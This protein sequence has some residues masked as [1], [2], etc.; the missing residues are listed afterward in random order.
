MGLHAAS[1]QP[2]HHRI[3]LLWRY[4]EHFGSKVMLAPLYYAFCL[5]ILGWWRTSSWNWR[6]RQR[7]PTC[8][9]QSWGISW[10]HP[11]AHIDTVSGW[12]LPDDVEW[13]NSATPTF[14]IEDEGIRD[15]RKT[16]KNIASS[17]ICPV[18]LRLSQFEG[19]TTARKS[20][21]SVTQLHEEMDAGCIALRFSSWFW[22]WSSWVW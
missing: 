21:Q 14:T 9:G 12:A 11:I 13:V 6:S 5:L 19:F 2:K 3:A 20:R 8:A 17:N 15:S 4:L 16:M 22:S 7:Q 10:D 1:F 18:V